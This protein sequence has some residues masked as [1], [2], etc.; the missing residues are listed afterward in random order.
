[1]FWWLRGRAALAAE[2]IADDTAALGSDRSTYART[3]LTLSDK[4]QALRRAPGL[5]PS[6]F[7][8][9]S[10]LTRR[11]EMLVRQ[12]DRLATSCSAGQRVVYAATTLLTVVACAATAR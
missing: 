7:R 3:L 1:L 8:K 5:V 10:E 2:V 6:T 9:R 12:H 11:I 4:L